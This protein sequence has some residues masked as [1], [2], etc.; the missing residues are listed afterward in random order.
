MFSAQAEIHCLLQFQAGV[1]VVGS[2]SLSLY[3]GRLLHFAFI[4]RS[5]FVEVFVGDAIAVFPVVTAGVDALQCQSV[6]R[7]YFVIE[8]Q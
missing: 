8:S 3:L 1:F 7:V 2:T 6:I 4:V 5:C